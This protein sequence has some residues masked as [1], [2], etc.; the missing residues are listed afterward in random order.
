MIKPYLNDTINDHKTPKN[1]RVHSSNE[2]ID[3]ETQFG[4]WKIQLAMQID[5]ISSEDSGETRTM[6]TKSRN[7]GIMM[8][9][10][11]N[12]IIEEPSESLL[13]N[14]QEGSGESMR[15]SEFV[16]DSIDLLFYH[17]QK[18]SWKKGRS[19]PDSSKWLKNKKATK[20]SKNNDNNCFQYALTV[21]L[22]YQNIKEDLQ[23]ISKIKPFI[24]QY[25]SKEVDFQKEQKDWKKF[26]LNNKSIALNI[27]FVPYNT[28]KN[29]TCIQIKI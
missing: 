7:I 21:T 4:E 26:E 17:L 8:G 22:N 15:R 14:Y 5:F 28:E 1:L 13:Q 24:N 11:T 18:I 23:R 2:V 12:D 6:H 25:N 20:N 29:K 27:L 9:S 3:Y 10:E 16:R 19:Y